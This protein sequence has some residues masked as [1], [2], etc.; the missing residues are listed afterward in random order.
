MSFRRA[1]FSFFIVACSISSILGQCDINIS[2]AIEDVTSGSVEIFVE[3]AAIN[4][5]SNPNQ[6]LCGVELFFEHTSIQDISISLQSPEGQ[7]VSLVGPA[8]GA[9]GNTQFTYWG[10]EFVP[11]DSTSSPDLPIL[12][13][14]FTTEDNWGIF[15]NYSGQYYP[16]QGCLEDFDSGVVN[17][18]WTLSFEDVQNFDT[19]SIDSISLIF[20][21]STNIV[22]MEC[23]ANGGMLAGADAD[24]C[25]SDPDLNLDIEPVF[26]TNEPSSIN[27]QYNYLV[28]DNNEIIQAIP[29][30]NLTDFAFGNY[31]VCG[32]SSLLDQTTEVLDDLIGVELDD[33]DEFISQN[34]YCAAMSSNCISIN[35]IEVPDTILTVDTICFGDAVVLDGTA[36]SQTGEYV[37]SFSQAFCDSVSILDLTVI[38]NQAIIDFDSDVIS[39]SDGDVQLDASNSITSPNTSLNWFKVDGVIDPSIESDISIIVDEAGTYGLSL[40]TGICSDTAYIEILN[41]DSIPSFEFDVDTLNCSNTTVVIETTPS[42]ELQSISWTG[43]VSSSEEDIEVSMSGIYYVEGIA[44]NGCVGRDSIYVESDYLVPEPIFSGDTMNCSI[45]EAMISS[46]LPDSISY[47]LEWSGPNILSPSLNENNILVA[48]DTAYILT[49]QNLNNGCSE[50]YDYT[51]QLDTSTIQFNIESTVYTCNLNESIVTATPALENV[52]Y[53]WISASGIEYFGDSVTV[54]EAGQYNLVSTFENGCTDTILHTITADTLAPIVTIEDVELSCLMDSIQ[55]IPMVTDP[56]LTFSWTGPGGFT[57]NEQSPFVTNPGLYWLRTENEEGCFIFTRAN[58]INGEGLPNVVFMPS[59]TIDCNTD[60][61]TLTPSDTTNL[62]FEWLSILVADKDAYEIDVIFNGLYPLIVTDTISGCS[63]FYEVVAPGSFQQPIPNVDEVG[64][65][66]NNSTITLNTSF[67]IEIDSLEWTSDFGF[68]STE[69]SPEITESGS[70]YITAVA[71]NGCQY[72]DTIVVSENTSLPIISTD[73]PLLDCQNETVDVTFDTQ[74]GSDILS[75]RLPNG[76]LISQSSITVSEP[77]SY[78]AIATTINGCVDSVLMQVLQDTVAADAE[79]IID[80]ELNCVDSTVTITVQSDEDNLSYH[81]SGGNIISPLGRDSIVIEK[82]GLFGVVVTDSSNCETVLSIVIEENVDLPMV[83]YEADT[84]SCAN[85]FADILLSTPSNTIGVTWQGPTLIPDNLTNVSVD[86]PGLYQATVTAD[87]NCFVTQEILVNADTIAPVVDVIVDGILDCQMETITLTGTSNDPDD[88]FQWILPN[89][90]VVQNENLEISEPGSYQVVVTGSNSCTSDSIV[91]IE[92]DTIFPVITT[93]PDP[94]FSCSD[95]KVFLMIEATTNIVSYAWEGP[96]E[97]ESD[98]EEPLA[99]APGLYTVTVTND[100]GCTAE[101]EINVIDDS[102]GPEISVRDTFITCDLLPVPLPLDTDD[103]EVSYTWDGPGFS[104][105]LPNPETNILGEYFI[106]AISDRNECVTID[107]INVTYK[108][109]PPEYEVQAQNISC[110]QSETT[111]KGINVDD[112]VSVTWTDTDFNILAMDSLEVFEADSFYVIVVGTND[113][114]DT[115]FVNIEEDFETVDL[116][117]IL[118]EPFQCDNTE[119][120]L[121]GNIIDVVNQE[122]FSVSWNSNDGVILSD[123]DA[124]QIDISGEGTY[125]FTV[126]NIENGC[127]SEDSILMIK[128]PQALLGFST[129][130]IEPQCNGSADGSITISNIEGGFSPFEYLLNG[131]SQMD[132]TFLNLTSGDYT[133]E[134]IDSVGC[135]TEVILNLNEGFQLEATAKNDTTIVIGDEIDLISIFNVPDN[136]IGSISWRSNRDDYDC[137]DCFEAPVSP[138]FNTIYT[139]EATTINGCIDTSEVFIKVI[140]NPKIDVANVFAPGSA[141]NGSFLIQQTSGI[142]KVLS[143]SIFDKWASRMF[144]AENINPGDPAGAWDGTYLGRD[145]NPGVYVVVAE[146]LLYSGEIVTYAG[147]ITLLR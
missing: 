85:T 65:G 7:Q 101:A 15:G 72:T 18:V 53:Q 48:Q 137:D 29:E 37:I 63:R 88:V 45:G 130:A 55:I 76:T 4:D 33:F 92:V 127:V 56:N 104:S 46:T 40:I 145:V 110:Y 44:T 34:G 95:G 64:F 144:F 78:M 138:L 113:C 57:S 94:I 129:E 68:N 120:P 22:C 1:F 146:L 60:R 132:S 90:D 136:E 6:G 58:V 39:C 79:F 124:F 12:D 35:I 139:L 121:I 75:I 11:C 119:V 96:L 84:I 59:D 66:C 80:G 112:D 133:L 103:D 27:Y 93:G 54:F 141:E 105:N 21:D 114:L 50:D 140:R 116:E 131:V 70:Y 87:N 97:Y 82:E 23:L 147:D 86:Q 99:I 25:E 31:Q 42:I 13:E 49:V 122:N 52:N 100:L 89:N 123:T 24:Y 71:I 77:N 98:L 36:Y 32:I 115:T 30:P 16:Q 143:I 91:L 126:T 109:V 74:N 9:G 14:V 106:Y 51:V 81:W 134:I 118:N 111:L 2:A 17:G 142:E 47:F 125:Y 128:D 28:F 135:S 41:D 5:L 108:E 19:G 117:I 43:L 67:E 3:G 38:D 61:I 69:Q 102:N 73:V 83:S 20:C 10:V 8:T 26:D 62:E 107:T